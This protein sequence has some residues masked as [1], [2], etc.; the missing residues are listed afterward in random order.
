MSIKDDLDK[1]FEGLV[2]ESRVPK[3][4]IW[5]IVKDE[6]ISFQE[7]FRNVS[8]TGL[9]RDTNFLHVSEFDK[10]KLPG[11]YDD[12][13]RGRVIFLEKSKKFAIYCSGKIANDKASIARVARDFSLPLKSLIVRQ[14]PHYE[15]VDFDELDFE[16]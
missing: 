6:V 13:E 3:I 14:D 9:S 8:S 10:L 4:G 16:D 12:Y 2:V 15:K 5:W 11:E 1:I 7:E